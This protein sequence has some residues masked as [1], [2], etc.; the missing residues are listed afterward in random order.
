MEAAHHWSKGELLYEQ[1]RYVTAVT[2]KLK[3]NDLALPGSSFPFSSVMNGT[4]LLPE[5][6]ERV[7][8]CECIEE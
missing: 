2:V 5:W 7:F 4:D 1:E 3:I 8:F 6:G